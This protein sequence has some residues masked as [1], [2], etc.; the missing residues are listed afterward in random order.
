MAKPDAIQPVGMSKKICFMLYGPPGAGKTKLVGERDQTL[1]IRPPTDHADS[2][3]VAGAEEWI[4]FDWAEMNNV[5]EYA[6]HDGA[7][8]FDWIWLDSISLFQDAGLDDIWDGVIAQKP[9]RAQYSL[10]KGEYGINM[11]RLQQWVRHMVGVP[12]FNFGIT[13]HPQELVEPI[14]GEIKLQPWIQGKNMSTKI[15]GY[16]N[17]V[18]YLEVVHQ[19][20][21]DIRVLRTAGTNRF[22][23]K[24]Q[25]DA[26][27]KG[28]LVDPTMDK[29]ERLVAKRRNAMA[30]QHNGATGTRRRTKRPVKR[31]AAR[32]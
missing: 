16:M 28:R 8:D 1:L 12:G 32:R 21:K 9:H 30:A 20:G 15:Q 23:A 11:W 4:V 17:I 22:E 5:M 26:F 29:I 3:R 31:S 25:F 6:R 10:D 19:E 24:D 14:S 18:G 13:A 2:I 27:A 7:K